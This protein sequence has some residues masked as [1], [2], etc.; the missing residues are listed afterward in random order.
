MGDGLVWLGV[1][2]LGGCGG[3]VDMWDDGDGISGEFGWGISVVG[4]GLDDVR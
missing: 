3:G 1:E 2:V 4:E